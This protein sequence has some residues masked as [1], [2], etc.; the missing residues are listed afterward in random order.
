LPVSSGA[1]LVSRVVVRRLAVLAALAW[2]MIKPASV[3]IDALE[4]R[5]ERHRSVSGDLQAPEGI[6]LRIEQ[7][8]DTGERG[9]LAKAGLEVF[10][11][12]VGG[13][14]SEVRDMAIACKD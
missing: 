6:V 5:K 9:R 4:E 2:N 1:M 7:R 14:G 11:V 13:F 3:G 12:R 10:P 8:V